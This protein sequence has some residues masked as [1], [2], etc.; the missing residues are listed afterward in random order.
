MSIPIKF[1]ACLFVVWWN[2]FVAW[3]LLSVVKWQSSISDLSHLNIRQCAVMVL[4]IWSTISH[5]FLKY[6]PSP[7]WLTTSMDY[8][9]LLKTSISV[10]FICLYHRRPVLSQDIHG[11][12]S[13]LWTSTKNIVKQ[14][15]YLHCTP[16]TSIWCMLLQLNGQW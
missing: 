14:V 12:C 3:F 1:V 5:H 2:Q 9:H 6:L 15:C 10:L 13:S 4:A 16:V 8:Y 7:Y 11:K